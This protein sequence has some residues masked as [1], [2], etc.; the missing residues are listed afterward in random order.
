M[1]HVHVQGLFQDFA[2]EGANAKF[3]NLG[4]GGNLILRGRKSQFLGGANG[5]R[6][7]GGQKNPLPP[8]PPPE[9]NLDVGRQVYLMQAIDCT[10]Q[11][12]P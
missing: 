6:G 7:G 9:I 3:Q 12:F 11:F 2:A 5:S 4:G 10:I 1:V 8:P